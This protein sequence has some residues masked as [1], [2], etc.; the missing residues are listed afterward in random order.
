V[1]Q[2]LQRLG[3]DSTN[4]AFVTLVE[5]VLG[6]ERN[7][8]SKSPKK[9]LASKME[10]SQEV[11]EASTA[12]RLEVLATLKSETNLFTPDVLDVV[13]DAL[14]PKTL[15]VA[16]FLMAVIQEVVFNGGR[17][18]QQIVLST[19]STQYLATLGSNTALRV[20]LG[21]E[22]EDREEVDGEE[23]CK[24]DDEDASASDSGGFGYS[25]LSV[26]TQNEE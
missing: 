16:A 8:L 13:K 19:A 7:R 10:Y 24:E 14:N 9:K 4:P 11:D 6:G 3:M 26:P 5:T 21:F 23:S 22:E 17:S 12:K 15:K 1:T 18:A 25:S 20:A 2:H